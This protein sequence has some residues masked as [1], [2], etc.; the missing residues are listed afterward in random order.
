MTLVSYTAASQRNWLVLGTR[1]HSIP[2]SCPS[3]SAR[4]CTYLRWFARPAHNHLD[5]WRLS[6]P[7]KAMVRFLRF[8]TGCHASPN[9][10]GAWDGL[11]RSQRLCTLCR[12]P[13]SDERHALLECPALTHLRGCNI[14]THLREQYQQLLRAHNRMRQLLFLWQSDNECLGSPVQWRA[15]SG[16]CVATSVMACPALSIA[17]ELIPV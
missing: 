10:A 6:L 2:R 7:R 12:S 11:P 15:L 3:E 14:S 16:C 13:Y 8:R 5:L 1:W 17:W 4:L 9:V